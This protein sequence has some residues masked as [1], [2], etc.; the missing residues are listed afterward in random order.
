M[1]FLFSFDISLVKVDFWF[2][3]DS[4]NV[5]FFGIVAKD[6]ISYQMWLSMMVFRSPTNK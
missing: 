4:F 2:A 5:D 3:E 1:I 6:L